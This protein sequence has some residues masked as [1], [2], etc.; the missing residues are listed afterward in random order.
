MT[1]KIKVYIWGTGQKAREYLSKSEIKDEQILGFVQSAK[2]MDTF[3]GKKVFAPEEIVLREYEYILVCVMCATRNIYNLCI[4]MNIPKEKLIFMDNFEWLDGTAVKDFPDLC[5]RVIAPCQ[6]NLWVEENFPIFYSLYRKWEE[7]LARLTMTTRTGHDLIDK[8]D[9][10]QKS[11]FRSWSYRKDYCRFRTFELMADEIN[12]KKIE[13][14]IAELGVYKGTFSRLINAKFPDKKLYLFDTFQSFDQNEYKEELEKERCQDGF[15]DVFK[16]TSVEKV[17]SNML[18][19][20]QCIP[21]VGFFPDTAD[22][23]REISFAFVS[24]DVDFEKSI[25][26]GLKYFY[27]RLN[28][29]GAIFVHDY[30]NSFLHGVKKAVDKYEETIGETLVRMPIA[31]E[32]GTLIILK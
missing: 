17:I 21:R 10:L 7:E 2:T 14:E 6:K 19:P 5:Y 30:N 31:D 16:D 26:E 29:G 9:F 8:E 4:Q 24:I 3:Y 18:H 28:K 20:E 15:I 23:L 32:G 25:Y 12:K 22:G 13:G 27:P 1:N 11:D